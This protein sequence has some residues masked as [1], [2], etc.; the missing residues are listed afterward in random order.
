M[1]SNFNLFSSKVG[2][3]KN[4]ALFYLFVDFKDFIAHASDLVNDLISVRELVIS[5]VDFR[6]YIF[7]LLEVFNA[8]LCAKRIFINVTGLFKMCEIPRY[9]T[10]DAGIFKYFRFLRISVRY[11]SWMRTRTAIL[12]SYLKISYEML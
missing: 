4:M 11:F 9:R 10:G 3:F 8:I 1:K 7:T 2:G 5:A 6:I 12:K